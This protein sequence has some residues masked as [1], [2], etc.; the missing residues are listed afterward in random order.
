MKK[1]IKGLVVIAIA[2]LVTVLSTLLATKA[3]PEYDVI[4]L[5]ESQPLMDSAKSFSAAN[6]QLCYERTEDA[7]KVCSFGFKYF[8]KEKK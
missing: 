1:N 8:I 6:G 3:K 7:R 4:I 2:V 5:L